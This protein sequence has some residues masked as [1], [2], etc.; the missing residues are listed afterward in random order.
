MKTTDENTDKL[1]SKLQ[2]SR[3]K[4]K[5]LEAQLKAQIKTVAADTEALARAISGK[6]ENPVNPIASEPALEV[7]Q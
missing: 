2:A 4:Q 6:P 1:L 7:A 3:A 5:K